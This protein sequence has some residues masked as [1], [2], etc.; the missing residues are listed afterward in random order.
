MSRNMS[1]HIEWLSLVE[2]SGPFLTVSLLEK[3]F[4]Q[5]LDRVPP[6]TKRRLRLAYEEWLD[7]IDEKDP[8]LSELHAEWIRLVFPELL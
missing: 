6:P 4:Q 7:A 3:E 2:V 1:Q 8:L 5:G